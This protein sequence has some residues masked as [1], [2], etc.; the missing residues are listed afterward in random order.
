MT[1]SISRRSAAAI[2]VIIALISAGFIALSSHQGTARAVAGPPTGSV[3]CV[4]TISGAIPPATVKVEG[5]TGLP[6]ISA[7]H[8]MKVP[9]DASSGELS[10]QTLQSPYEFTI[11]SDA[12]SDSNIALITAMINHE[13]LK[14]CTFRYYHHDASGRTVLYLTVVLNN[15]HLVSHEFKSSGEV[16]WKAVFQKITWKSPNGKS[17][18]TNW[19]APVG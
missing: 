7:I 5:S 15:A 13:N 19:S 3:A 9:F 12:A 8:S 17:A 2:A 18:T 10:G 6:L 11:A 4:G 16:T 1:I 14:T